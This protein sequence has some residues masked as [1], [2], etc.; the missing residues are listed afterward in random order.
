[1]ETFV[2]YAW[3]G[4]QYGIGF[5]TALA[6]AISYDNNHQSSGPSSTD[7]SAGST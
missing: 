6:I 4:A 1:M 5:G 3:T 7:S 2:T